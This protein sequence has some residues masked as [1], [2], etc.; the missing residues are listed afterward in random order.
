MYLKR[1][2]RLGLNGIMPTVDEPIYGTPLDEIDFHNWT[3]R[4]GRQHDM[5]VRSYLSFLYSAAA[6]RAYCE[7]HPEYWA[8]TWTGKK[9]PDNRVCL[10]HA[11]DGD[12]YDDRKTGVR[13]G[14]DNPWLGRLYEAVKRA[15]KVNDLQGVWWDFEL[16]AVPVR[17]ELPIPYNPQ[18]KRQVCT[19]LRCRRAF[20]DYAKLD[21]VPSV[22]EIMSDKYYEA[23]DDFKCR[24]NTRLWA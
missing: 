21:Q 9:T 13:G 7:R 10:T 4:W 24:Q 1:L 19:C 6:S 14:K 15:V 5:A 2:E 20:A 11:L 8:E 18:A 3:A 23:W 17:K 22:Q 12:K 16:S